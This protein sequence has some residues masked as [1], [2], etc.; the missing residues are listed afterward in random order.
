M[1]TIYDVPIDKLLARTAI[2]LKKVDTIKPPVWAPYVKTGAHKERPPVDSD[3]WYIRTASILRKV[4]ILGP[5]G[6]SKLQTKY[7]GK[8]NR[9]HKPERH[10][11][12]SGSI[13]RKI[14]QQLEAAGLLLKEEK[15]V[16]RGR[17]V[18]PKGQSFLDKIASSL[19]VPKKVAAKKAAEPKQEAPA[20]EVPK[21]APKAEPPKEQEE[22]AT[23][24]AAKEENKQE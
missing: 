15:Q 1:A 23:V 4:S 14:L 11:D 17:K 13:I 10:Y 21:E 12:G 6:T 20:S 16:H 7:G 8:K 9:G 3:W 24:E 22:K 18:S 19:Y 2:E 5:I